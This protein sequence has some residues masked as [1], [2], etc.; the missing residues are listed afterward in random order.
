MVDDGCGSLGASHVAGIYV[1]ADFLRY[2]DPFG[3]FTDIAGVV[4]LPYGNRKVSI[5][6]VGAARGVDPTEYTGAIACPV[7]KR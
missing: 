4:Q 3:E 1:R 5:D 6:V 2:G 7:S